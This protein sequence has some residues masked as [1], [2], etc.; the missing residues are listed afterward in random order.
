MAE[1]EA[2]FSIY[3]KYETIGE[4]LK[5]ISSSGQPTLGLTPI[6]YLNEHEQILF[7]LSPFGEGTIINY[8]TLTKDSAV[9]LKGSELIELEGSAEKLNIHVMKKKNESKSMKHESD[10][11]KEQEGSIPEELLVTEKEKKPPKSGVQ[12]LYIPII[13]VEKT[14]LKFPL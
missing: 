11:K 4:M 7:M 9:K 1:N 14:S 10:R 12:L 6:L 5:V 13:R 3:L 2:K 8:T